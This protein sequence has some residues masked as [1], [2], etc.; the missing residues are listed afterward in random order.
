[1]FHCIA[2]KSCL[3]AH[4]GY[5]K[6][7]HD[8]LQ[9]RQVRMVARSDAPAANHDLTST[10][11]VLT[12]PPRSVKHDR[13]APLPQ[14]PFQEHNHRRGTLSVAVGVVGMASCH[15]SMNLPLAE[16]ILAYKESR[17]GPRAK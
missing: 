7:Q 9:L 2:R 13:V 8:T 14:P 1:M 3:Q 6:V 5:T 12:K 15:H 16:G 11:I 4:N 17:R 10:F